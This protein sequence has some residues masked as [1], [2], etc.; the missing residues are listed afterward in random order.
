MNW[1]S[2]PPRHPTL[3]AVVID[4][5]LVAVSASVVGMVLPPVGVAPAGAVS[6]LE[7]VLRPMSWA[8]I[9]V[10]CVP[11]VLVTRC[12][13]RQVMDTSSPELDQAAGQAGSLPG[14]TVRVCNTWSLDGSS[15]P[16][17]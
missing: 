4:T 12:S 16:R 14:A 17:I 5:V 11:A 1:R 6:P 15:C 8:P 3:P 13:L 10:F 9:Q 2:L 7:G